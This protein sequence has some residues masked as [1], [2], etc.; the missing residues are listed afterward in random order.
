MGISKCRSEAEP[1]RFSF[2]LFSSFFRKQRVREKLLR[3]RGSSS[4]GEEKKEG[5]EVE[6]KEQDDPAPLRRPPVLMVTE[7]SFVPGPP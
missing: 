7:R 2:V 5:H 6:L 3:L 4:G 1:R